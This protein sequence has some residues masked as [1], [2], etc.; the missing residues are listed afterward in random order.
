MIYVVAESNKWGTFCFCWTATST[1]NTQC[2]TDVGRNIKTLGCL[3]RMMVFVL[4]T[5]HL[6]VPFI[7]SGFFLFKH[8]VELHETWQ[9]I[10]NR[11]NIKTSINST[12]QNLWGNL[13]AT[14]RTQAVK[15]VTGVWQECQWTGEEVGFLPVFED[16]RAS[17]KG[18]FQYLVASTRSWCITWFCLEALWVK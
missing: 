12:P 5:V 2:I 15:W 7:F 14:S 3:W 16:V 8:I 11:H 1:K 10:T 4:P 18:L 13:Q 17:R 9:T 6:H